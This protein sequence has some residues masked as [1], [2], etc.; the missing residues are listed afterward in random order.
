M[1]TGHDNKK[2]E[3]FKDVKNKLEGIEE[4]A[5]YETHLKSLKI[6]RNISA[7]WKEPGHEM[8]DE[9]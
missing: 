1:G 6:I 5:E 8:I 4:S 3:W 2:T 9:L 7:N